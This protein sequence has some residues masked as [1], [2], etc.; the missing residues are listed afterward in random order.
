MS[1]IAERLAAQLNAG[2]IDE[3]EVNL[4]LNYPSR[5]FNDREFSD[6][7]SLL[8]DL[9]Q[10]TNPG[11]TDSHEFVNNGG[12]STAEYELRFAAGL[13]RVGSLGFASE[14]D[15]NRDFEGPYFS[16]R[17]QLEE[18]PQLRAFANQ[19]VSK[20]TLLR[21]TTGRNPSKP[22]LLVADDNNRDVIAAS[23]NQ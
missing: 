19:R 13:G 18:F 3:E 6:V 20:A 4:L 17:H 23:T 16:L 5:E 10:Y 21:P 11:R 8:P 9:A 12:R 7:A 22:M 2:E 14:R 15:M 1:T